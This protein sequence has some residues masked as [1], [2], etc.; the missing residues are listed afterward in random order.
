MEKKFLAR[1]LF[2]L[3]FVFTGAVHMM[4][5]AVSVKYFAISFDISRKSKWERHIVENS[6]LL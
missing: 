5:Y 3:L 2:S 6:S 1:R 4:R